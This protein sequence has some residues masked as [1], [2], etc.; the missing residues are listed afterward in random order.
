MMSDNFI[1]K[2]ENSQYIWSNEFFKLILS[3]G[4][5]QAFDDYS[6]VKDVKDIMYLYYNVEIFAKYYNYDEDSEIEKF[7]WKKISECYVYDFPGI[8]QLKYILEKLLSN[9]IP[10]EEYRKFKYFNSNAIGYEYRLGTEG[11]AND[12]HYE[13]VKEI[14]INESDKRESYTFYMGCKINPQG[15]RSSIGV[16]TNYINRVDLENLLRM[17]DTFIQDCI[18]VHNDN[19]MEYLEGALKS[20]SVNDSKLM[21]TDKKGNVLNI[22]LQG[23][24]V[25]LSVLE[26]LLLENNFYSIEYNDVKIIEIKEKEISFEY[27]VDGEIKVV[28]VSIDKIFSVFNELL[29]EESYKLY[30][31]ELDICDDMMSLL[32]ECDKE[33]FRHNNEEFLFEKWKECIVN[34]YWLCR[35]EHN[36]PIRQEDK[37]NHENVY[38]CAKEIIVMLK[39][40][41]NF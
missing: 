19:N 1:F 5:F 12:D 8:I 2:K 40:K 17:I 16:R 32:S 14:S 3:K 7:E 35:E 11:F 13:V 27:I 30:W 36:L 37:G 41:M 23:D 34:R 28:S 29:S 22:F 21:E 18:K 33:E 25:T 4:S 20:F 9:D 24:I 15:D 31:N 26:G 39:E 10:L 38:A 6:Y